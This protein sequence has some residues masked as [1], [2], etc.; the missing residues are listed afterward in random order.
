MSNLTAL[1]AVIIR[2]ALLYARKA[3]SPGEYETQRIET[4]YAKVSAMFALPTAMDDH[5]SVTPPTPSPRPTSGFVPK[6]EV[7]RLLEDT[8]ANWGL[9][10]CK[11]EIHIVR[12]ASATHDMAQ[13]RVHGNTYRAVLTE[14]RSWLRRADTATS[15]R[16]ELP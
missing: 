12:R 13:R 2:G 9:E 5:P 10:R 16:W 6:A 7:I 4:A 1:D 11:N 8:T 15:V 3:A 14:L